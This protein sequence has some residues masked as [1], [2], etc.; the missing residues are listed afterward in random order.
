MVV[1]ADHAGASHRALGSDFP[2]IGAW[3]HGSTTRSATVVEVTGSTGYAV[4]AVGPREN[5]A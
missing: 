3:L 2:S 5:A 4:T 1:R